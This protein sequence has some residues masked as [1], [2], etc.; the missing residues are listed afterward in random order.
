M[1]S[2]GPTAVCSY[3]QM[4]KDVNGA[5]T[6]ESLRQAAA[7]MLGLKLRGSVNG[8]PLIEHNIGLCAWRPDED[9]SQ[10]RLLLAEIERRNIKG[11]FVDALCDAVQCW[12]LSRIRDAFWLIAN[13]T[14]K[15]ITEAA[16]KAIGE[17][18]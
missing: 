11:A 8:Y 4:G 3:D 13:A 15:Q 7:E 16:V 10:A 1:A 6:P 2:D 5:M 17:Q 18:P 14:P 9:A 12:H